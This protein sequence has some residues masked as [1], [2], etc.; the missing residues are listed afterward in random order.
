MALSRDEGEPGSSVA[1]FCFAPIGS[2]GTQA[3]NTGVSA[4]E[5]I[6]GGV[7]P[8]QAWNRVE[9]DVEWVEVRARRKAKAERSDRPWWRPQLAATKRAAV[10]PPT[11]GAIGCRAC[12]GAAPIRTTAAATTER[13]TDPRP[14]QALAATFDD[15]RPEDVPSGNLFDQPVLTALDP[16]EPEERQAVERLL[17]SLDE[18]SA[19]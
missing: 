13:M 17:E 16:A 3:T 11:D 15:T 7:E 5:A 12:S 1:R 18:D 8:S 19:N 6:L 14:E 9:Q 2:A 10:P 4:M